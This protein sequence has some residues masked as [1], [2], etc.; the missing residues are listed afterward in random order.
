MFSVHNICD[1]HNGGCSHLCLRSP[2]KA[3][4]SCACPTGI[5]MSEDGK[6]CEKGNNHFMY[7][8]SLI[9]WPKIFRDFTYIF[10]YEINTIWV[11][12]VC[13]PLTGLT[14]H[15]E[16]LSFVGNVFCG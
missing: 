1:E 9:H 14:C 8:M 6:T 15:P 3:G 11:F 16:E 4:F 12:F 10:I 7:M 13:I 2:N 5:L